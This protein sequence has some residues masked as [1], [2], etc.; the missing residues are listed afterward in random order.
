[1]KFIHIGDLHIGKRVND[2]SMLENQRHV[3]NQIL[4]CAKKLQVDGIL[5][6]GD[7]YDKTIPT[8]E[9][10]ELFETFLEQIVKL[11]TPVYIVSGNHDSV[12]RLS[13]F[14]SLIKNNKI[15]ISR[16]FTNEIEPIS[17]GDC[18]IWLLP[19]VRPADVRKYFPDIEIGN[20]HQAVEQVIKNLKINNDKINILVAH[21]FVT[22]NGTLPQT[23][24]SEICSLGTL[25]N[26]D[27]S[28]FKDFDYV[29]LGHIHKPQSMGAKNVRYCGS[30]LKYSFSEVN[31]EKSITVIDI[32]KNNFKITTIP[33]VALNDMKEI[34]GSM[35][36]LLKMP[37]DESYLHITL[38]DNEIIDAKRKL[39]MIFPNI[40]KL[41]FERYSGNTQISANL[42]NLKEKNVL[43]HF[44]DF[45]EKQTSHK[46]T[47]KEKAIVMEFLNKE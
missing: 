26:V 46:I 15:Y 38:T 35:E 24:D 11:K 22:A 25:D 44:E 34:K 4:E 28:V 7:V 13:M 9:A 39:E 21:Q 37:Y 42:K 20:Y 10:I 43:E 47:E 31:Q 5:I 45:F 23:S 14:S 40:M 6:A 12:E 1:M 19:F 3:L 8:V 27:F 29:A 30:P 16:H 36:S 41:D 33:F 32:K 17:N 2:F 18:D